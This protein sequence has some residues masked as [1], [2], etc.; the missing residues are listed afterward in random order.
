M[1]TR[2]IGVYVE[3]LIQSQNKLGAITNNAFTTKIDGRTFKAHGPYRISGT[4]HQTNIGFSAQINAVALAFQTAGQASTV[5]ISNLNP[6]IINKFNFQPAPVVGNLGCLFRIYRRTIIVD[7][8][9]RIS[10]CLRWR[11]PRA[12]SWSLAVRK[13]SC[14]CRYKRF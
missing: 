4:N 8:D 2:S 12:V 9:G 13:S 10:Y 11:R 3:L 5:S 14:A 6:A 7:D 1:K